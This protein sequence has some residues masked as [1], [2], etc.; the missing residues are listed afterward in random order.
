MKMCC[1]GGVN[2]KGVNK[3]EGTRE[4]REG[5]KGTTRLNLL[6]K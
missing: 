1:L 5:G 6:D 4:R 3:G 2:K